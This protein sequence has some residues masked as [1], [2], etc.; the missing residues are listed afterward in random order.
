MKKL[1]NKG[2]SIIELLV[3]FVIVAVISVTLLNIIMDYNSLQETEHIKNLIKS[4]K[5]TVTKTIQSDI[6]KYG[7]SDVNVDSTQENELKL[8]LTFNNLPTIKE[9]NSKT[10][11]LIVHASDD[12]NYIIYQ[13]TVK[14]DEDYINQDVKYLLPTTTNINDKD[15]DGNKNKKDIR[16]RELP[17]TIDNDR[18]IT[19]DI[20]Y[21]YIPIE[22]SEIDDTYGIRII[23]PLTQ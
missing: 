22:H 15:S 6:I 23:A 7:L 2:L 18:F 19:N 3:C 16:F 11:Y 14:E 5:N 4:Y 10:K 20:F 8:I 1:N 17:Q 13:D 9:D 21:L 12:E